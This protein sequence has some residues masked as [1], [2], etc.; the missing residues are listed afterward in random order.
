[1]VETVEEEAHISIVGE[2]L[3][4]STESGRVYGF[5]KP[6]FVGYRE[7]RAYLIVT[8]VL[9]ILGALL[10]I[11]LQSIPTLRPEDRTSALYMIAGF[12][13]A[14]IIAALI[15]KKHLMIESRAGTRIIFKKVDVRDRELIALLEK[16]TVYNHYPTPTSS[17]EQ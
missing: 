1:L 2:Y 7:Y 8:I 5:Y 16:L 14:G 10:F 17:K 3:V 4:L 13:I 12:F 15:K 11:E 9:F 6:S